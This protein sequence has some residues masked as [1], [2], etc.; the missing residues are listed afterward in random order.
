ML[1][2]TF[3][4][5]AA[6]ILSVAVCASGCSFLRAPTQPIP[7]DF[8]SS[9]VPTRGL[10][11]F[12]PGFGDGP[13][14]FRQKGLVSMVHAQ[15]GFDVVAVDAHFGY[16]RGFSIVDRLHEDIIEPL[17]GDYQS[18]WLVG[19]SMGG[20]GASSYAMDHP[21]NVTG[22]MLLAPYMGLRKVVA[23]VS[24]AGGLAGWRAPDLAS[25]DDA[26][27]R[28]SYRLWRWYQGYIGASPDRSPTLALGFGSADRG[29]GS[30]LIEAV[31]PDAQ[32]QVLPGDHNWAVWTPL[33]EALLSRVANPHASSSLQNLSQ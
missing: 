31:L 24:D 10:V 33:F 27:T 18:I 22:V 9:G 4:L 8:H 12:L 5:L 20:F 15:T 1:L 26:R 32:V 23:E 3:R 16:Y 2:I 29:V 21:S 6:A 7:Y 13:E 30:S 17:R 19:V 25:I 14:R 11:V 28:H